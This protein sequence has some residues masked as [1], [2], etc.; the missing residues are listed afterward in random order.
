MAA[1]LQLLTYALG[2][3]SLDLAPRGVGF[4][5]DLHALRIV[6]RSVAVASYPSCASARKRRRHAPWTSSTTAPR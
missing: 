1:V 2:V 6:A 4:S 3:S 5:F